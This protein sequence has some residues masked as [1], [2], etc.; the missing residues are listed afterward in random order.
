MEIP[1]VF[2]HST[3]F[4]YS[5]SYSFIHLLFSFY[6]FTLLKNICFFFLILIFMFFGAKSCEFYVMYVDYFYR[7]ATHKVRYK[8]RTK[9][10]TLFG[11]IVFY[12]DFLLCS[13]Y[14][15]S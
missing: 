10:V 6:F 11:N 3:V 14:A 15:R 9:G 12:M 7:K 13:L 8:V 2:L 4:P 1:N 5:P